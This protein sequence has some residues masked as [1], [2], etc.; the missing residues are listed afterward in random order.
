MK[1]ILI[2]PVVYLNLCS[3]IVTQVCTVNLFPF[4]EMGHL[5]QAFQ[6]KHISSHSQWYW[7]I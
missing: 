1:I 3:V 4:L 5:K 6:S 2:L 7:T